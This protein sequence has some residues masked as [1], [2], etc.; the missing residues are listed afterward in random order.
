MMNYTSRRLSNNQE[1]SV[2]LSW[3]KVSISHG[4]SDILVTHEFC[5]SISEILPDC[6]NQDANA[7]RMVRRVV[8][9][10][11]RRL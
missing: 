4:L 1:L 3:E 7:C 10:G 5:N 2:Y 11:C 6:A 9:Y 8:A